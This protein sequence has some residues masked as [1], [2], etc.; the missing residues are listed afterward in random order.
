MRLSGLPAL[1]PDSPA[2][3][4]QMGTAPLP[5]ETDVSSLSQRL[6]HEFHIEIPIPV[7]AGHKL[8]RFSLQAYNSEEDVD[9]LIRALKQLI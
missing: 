3:Y 4:A 8:V 9:Q 2:W 7:W 5:A 6:F 1:Y